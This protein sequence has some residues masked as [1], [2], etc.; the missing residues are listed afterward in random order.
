MSIATSSI[1]LVY[2]SVLSV[3]DAS[4]RGSRRMSTANLRD[5]RYWTASRVRTRVDELRRDLEWLN[6]HHPELAEEVRDVLDE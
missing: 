4:Y 5:E 1:L 3:T 6:D 2:L